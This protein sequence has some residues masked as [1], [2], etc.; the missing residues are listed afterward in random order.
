MLRSLRNTL[1]H[2]NSLPDPGEMNGLR[3]IRRGREANFFEKNR[4]SSRRVFGIR[5]VANL[6]LP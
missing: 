3:G 4:I 1:G 5:G 6:E 2:P